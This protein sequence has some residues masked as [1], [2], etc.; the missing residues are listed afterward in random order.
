[1]PIKVMTTHVN[2]CH[3]GLAGSNSGSACYFHDD[4]LHPV[5]SATP[6]GHFIPRLL[7]TTVI[8]CDGEHGCDCQTIS[9]SRLTNYHCYWLANVYGIRNIIGYGCSTK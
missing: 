4:D 1:V 2:N 7:T 5:V 9:I 3:G 8:K 6:G